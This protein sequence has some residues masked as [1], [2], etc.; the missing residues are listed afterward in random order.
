MRVYGQPTPGAGAKTAQIATGITGIGLTT[1]GTI[2]GAT[3][4]G[5]LGGPIGAILG[6][7]GYDVCQSGPVALLGPGAR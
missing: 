1:A 4:T 7:L 6:A 3:V 2:V 5:A